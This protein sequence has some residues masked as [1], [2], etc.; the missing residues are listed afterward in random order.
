MQQRRVVTQVDSHAALP[1]ADPDNLAGLA[2]GQPASCTLAA[3]AGAANISLV[4]I[5]VKDDNGNNIT[6]PTVLVV[7]L[8]DA[9]SGAGLTATTAS[10]AVAAGASGVD[11]DA[12]VSKKALYVQTDA[13][14]KYI[15]SITDTAKT[16][17]YVVAE[18]PGKKVNVSAQLA[19]ASYG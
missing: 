18:I 11:L 12:M 5:Q 9:A 7:S 6:A 16:H 2:A 19:D 4:T 10:G 1:R 17:F 14:G 15:L 3:A 13:T 8:S